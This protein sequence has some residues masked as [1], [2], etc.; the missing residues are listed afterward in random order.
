MPSLGNILVEPKPSVSSSTDGKE[1]LARVHVTGLMCNAVCARRVGQALGRL[2][3]VTKVQ[4]H[5]ASDTFTLWF[6]GPPVE[7]RD[8]HEAVARQVLF[9]RL[10]CWLGWLG[11]VLSGPKSHEP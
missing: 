3:G 4:F 5:G 10:R 6:D 8:L 7:E 11:R 9:P 1:G 2:P